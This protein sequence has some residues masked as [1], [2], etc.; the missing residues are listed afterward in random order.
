MDSL[1]WKWEQQLPLDCGAVMATTYDERTKLSWKPPVHNRT[2]K[3]PPMGDVSMRRVASPATRVAADGKRERAAHRWEPPDRTL[4]GASP[5][6]RYPL[7]ALRHSPAFTA[8]VG[9]LEIKDAP[10][11]T[12]TAQQKQARLDAAPWAQDGQTVGAF[13]VTLTVALNAQYRGGL[14]TDYFLEFLRAF[15]GTA[16]D[17]AAAPH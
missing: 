14:R 5:E 8:A 10:A 6:V 1:L 15:L 2:V 17:R 13:L 4:R 12:F 9:L 11:G 7:R 3:M 16:L